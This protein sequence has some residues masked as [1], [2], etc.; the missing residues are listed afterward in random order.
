MANIL[1]DLSTCPTLRTTK[2]QRWRNKQRLLISNRFFQ[3]YEKC[4]ALCQ[5]ALSLILRELNRVCLL[6]DEAPPKIQFRPKIF[7]NLEMVEVDTRTLL[8]PPRPPLLPHSTPP[9]ASPDPPQPPPPD[10][11][12]KVNLPSK[13]RKLEERDVALL[14]NPLHPTSQN[15]QRTHS[16]LFDFFMRDFPCDTNYVEIEDVVNP[17]TDMKRH[18]HEIC[19]SSEIQHSKPWAPDE[20]P[21]TK[22]FPLL[23][24]PQPPE[25]DLHDV[26]NQGEVNPR[27]SPRSDCFG[28]PT[29]FAISVLCAPDVIKTLLSANNI[30]LFM[31]APPPLTLEEDHRARDK[32]RLEPPQEPTVVVI[33]QVNRGEVEKDRNYNSLQETALLF[34]PALT[35][36][37]RK[38]TI[39]AEG[40]FSRRCSRS[41][42]SSS[43]I[44]SLHG[45]PPPS[46]AVM[47]LL[48]IL[49]LSPPPEPS[50]ECSDRINRP[51]RPKTPKSHTL[52]M[53]HPP[54][55]EV[56][57]PRRAA[58]EEPL[59]VQKLSF[60]L[61]SPQPPCLDLPDYANK[62]QR[63]RQFAKQV[64][65]NVDF[66]FT[67][68]V[69]SSNPPTPR[70]ALEPPQEVVAEVEDIVNPGS[71]LRL[72][73]EIPDIVVSLS[74]P[75][76]VKETP[77]PDIS[78]Q[79]PLVPLIESTDTINL[80][81]KIS[82]VWCDKDF[83]LDMAPLL[84]GTISTN[85]VPHVNLEPPQAPETM[86]DDVAN[87]AT[88]KVKQ[89]EEIMIG[90]VWAQHNQGFDE[91]ARFDFSDPLPLQYPTIELEDKELPHSKS[92]KERLDKEPDIFDSH[93]TLPHS[94]SDR[95]VQR[96]AFLVKQQV[97]LLESDYES[98][99]EEE[100]KS[101]FNSK[102]WLQEES[103]CGLEYSPP[104][105]LT[106]DRRDK[107]LTFLFLQEAPPIDDDKEGLIQSQSK[108]V[109]DK[110]LCSNCSGWEGKEATPPC[111]NVT[112]AEASC[113]YKNEIKT[114]VDYQ[115][116]SLSTIRNNKVKL[117]EDPICK[118]DIGFANI[119]FER[120]HDI[121][122]DTSTF[123]PWQLGDPFTEKLQQKENET[124][125][126]NFSEEE[127]KC[128]EDKSEE[129]KCEGDVKQKVAPV[130]GDGA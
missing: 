114:F 60:E 56:N 51:S 43:G 39:E 17:T 79:T 95:K 42:S 72:L 122:L 55:I 116:R 7:Q 119:I 112:Q 69:H 13:V 91:V 19:V 75:V 33:D 103:V 89:L 102:V 118:E 66:F 65:P 105:L 21:A 52:L 62:Q 53:N 34:F 115:L 70:F 96:P 117:F 45:K 84:L 35:F 30:S 44:R 67:P 31:P 87:L 22:I 121:L 27:V 26:D 99:I 73:S 100:T 57:I 86:V 68:P 50:S 23:Q 104:L 127:D 10:L 11:E 36:Q 80:G 16:D 12:D 98:K 85:H 128:K 25:L 48:Q 5:Y 78:I 63:P 94:I 74:T 24:P 64:S 6:V 15:N 111:L 47:K 88:V 32:L 82:K 46:S 58:A 59:V 113:A 29:L 37:D 101:T 49:T 120:P 8:E 2:I 106:D 77:R 54:Y 81:S 9:P 124:D 83:S 97:P 20:R 126:K 93:L 4:F 1:L 110:T 123:L 109:L 76:V 130:I 107:V 61:K 38:E 71:K 90:V 129:D 28:L 92:I 125:A 18:L 108:E 14:L 3:S 41:L 40:N